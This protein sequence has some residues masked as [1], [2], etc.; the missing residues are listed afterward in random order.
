M[1][2]VVDP[3]GVDC[4]IAACDAADLPALRQWLGSLPET[5][6]GRVF[7]EVFAPMQI[8]Q[9]P[10][11]PHVGVTWLCREEREASP[12][13]GIGR[14]RGEALATAVDAWFDEWVWADS[15]AVRNIELWTG[16]RSCPVMQNYWTAL[17]RRLEKRWPGGTTQRTHATS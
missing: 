11:P 12:R 1:V 15:E 8:E 9:L 6:Y 14:R 7:V 16:A 17:D 2:S 3:A 4:V 10:V 5:S 13:P